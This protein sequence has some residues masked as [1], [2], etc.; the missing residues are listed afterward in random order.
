MKSQVAS[1]MNNQQSQIA[2][3]EDLGKG[4]LAKNL[5]RDRLL[6]QVNDMF[7]YTKEQNAVV[8]HIRQAKMIT[9]MIKNRLPNVTAVDEGFKEDVTKTSEELT[10]FDDELAVFM[11]RNASSRL[12]VEEVA[13][14]FRKLAEKN[15][16]ELPEEWGYYPVGPKII[17]ERS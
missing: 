6:E 7:A 9:K 13:E 3:V 12:Q 15:R 2:V 5:E 11:H 17:Q 1:M 14:H 4:L 8:N 16:S 10:A